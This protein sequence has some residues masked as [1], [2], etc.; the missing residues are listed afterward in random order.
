MSCSPLKNGSIKATL[1]SCHFRHL[2]NRNKWSK[3]VKWIQKRQLPT[4]Q[5]RYF[6]FLQFLRLFKND[7]KGS[8]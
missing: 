2:E 7:S 5:N 1:S 6:Q 3:T 4:F 8:N